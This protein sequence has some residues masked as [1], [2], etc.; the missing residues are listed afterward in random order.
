MFSE[1]PSTSTNSNRRVDFN[2][3][4]DYDSIVHINVLPRTSWG[5]WSVGLAIAFILFFALSEVLIGFEPLGPGFNPV[6]ALALTIVLAGISGAAFVT[7]LISM[8]KS[9]ERSAFVF[10]T[11]ARRIETLPRPRSTAFTALHV[12]LTAHAQ[13]FIPDYA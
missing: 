12:K 8:I 7:G 10:L 13:R 3:T 9:K 4:A 5:R 1:K 11:T 6:L 2:H